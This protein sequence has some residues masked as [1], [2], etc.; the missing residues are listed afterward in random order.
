MHIANDSPRRMTAVFDEFALPEEDYRFLRTVVPVRLA[1]FGEQNLVSRSQARRLVARF[2]QFR[3]VV[4]DFTG[5]DTIGQAFAD[6]VF[7]VFQR[8]NPG[9]ELVVSNANAQ[10]AKMIRRAKAY[11][12]G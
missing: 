11:Q 8:A 10:V 7:R 6:E 9:V 2:E 1:Q 3:T 5:V 12:P 4:L